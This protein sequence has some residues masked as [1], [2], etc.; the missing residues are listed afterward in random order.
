MK[1]RLPIAAC[2]ASALLWVA[3]FAWMTFYTPT[4]P[5]DVTASS[6]VPNHA[7][8]G[9]TVVISRAIK[10]RTGE[11]VIVTRFMVKGDCRI[12]CEK[13][14]LPSG[15]FQLDPGEYPDIRR[16]FKIPETAEIGRWQLLFVWNW[17]DIFGRSWTFPLPPLDLEVIP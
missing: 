5:Y 11:P 15:Y 2:V 9:G 10:A 14:D 13:F 16:K 6:I 1:N 4:P 7:K 12:A 17:R 3:T 8:A